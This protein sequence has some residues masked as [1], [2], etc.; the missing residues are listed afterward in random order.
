MYTDH[1][2]CCPLV[3]HGEYADGTDRRTGR[4]TPDRHITLSATR[5]QSKNVKKLK[6]H[7]LLNVKNTKT[8]KQLHHLPH[9][10]GEDTW[11]SW[12]LTEMS[13]PAAV[14]VSYRRWSGNPVE[15][16]RFS[17]TELE[18]S[19]E[20]SV[21]SAAT[22][23]VV[24]TRWNSDTA[25]VVPPERRSAVAAKPRHAT[26]CCVNAWPSNRFEKFIGSATVRRTT[27]YAVWYLIDAELIL[28]VLYTYFFSFLFCFFSWLPFFWRWNKVI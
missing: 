15:P 21:P 8:F 16:I 3:S 22:V 1:V 18:L 11:L 14:L 26:L 2:A 13:T 12:E 23:V 24:G 9:L 4:R 27:T 19:S 17:T 20:S 7:V 28:T 5:C 10:P 6:M 25:S